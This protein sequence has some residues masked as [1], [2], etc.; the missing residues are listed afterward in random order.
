MYQTSC[1]RIRLKPGS[2]ARARAW[3]KEMR[4]RKEEALETLRDESV[5][6]ESVFL[7]HAGDGD[8]LIY[9]LKR[10]DLSRGRAVARASPHPIDAVHREFKEAA[11]T[12]VEPLELLLDLDRIG[13]S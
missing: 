13:Q 1:V 7:E 9:F 5:V 6:V 3:A 8:F 4:Q 12:T 11:W 10:E 2:L